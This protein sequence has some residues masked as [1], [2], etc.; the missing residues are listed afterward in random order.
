M[1][2]ERP[3][4]RPRNRPRSAS[5]Q[6]V[7]RTAHEGAG[8]PSSGAGDCW[9]WRA[10]WPAALGPLRRAAEGNCTA[11]N[12][13]LWLESQVRRHLDTDRSN[14]GHRRRCT[15]RCRRSRPWTG[16]AGPARGRSRRTAGGAR[17][18]RVG[19]SPTAAA[20]ARL[21]GARQLAPGAQGVS[22]PTATSPG[23]RSRRAGAH[24]FDRPGAANF[25][26]RRRPC[27][28]T[29]SRAIEVER[30]GWRWIGEAKLAGC[31]SRCRGAQPQWEQE[32]Q[33]HECRP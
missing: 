22:L 19:R 23:W 31:V 5:G 12:P 8:K 25:I 9:R 26:Q 14:A 20:G 28:H 32:E 4:S 33:R 16:R 24:D 15:G 30:I 11:K 21:L 7:V 13:E 6:S 18:E 29:S 3:G 2:P 17:A 10:K 27:S 1:A